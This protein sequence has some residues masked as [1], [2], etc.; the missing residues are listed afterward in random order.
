MTPLYF[1]FCCVSRNCIR[2]SYVIKNLFLCTGQNTRE[3]KI[4]KGLNTVKPKKTTTKKWFHDCL[5]LN[6]GKKMQNKESIQQYVPPSL[7]FL[8][9]LRSLF[10]LFLSGLFSQ[11]YCNKM[12]I[13]YLHVS[14]S[15]QTFLAM[16]S[17]SVAILHGYSSWFRTIAYRK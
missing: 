1:S 4:F 10:C 8:L 3:F 6:A 5:S 16:F 15:W 11:A 14:T 9:S 17:G 2:L 12:S 7:S 13:R